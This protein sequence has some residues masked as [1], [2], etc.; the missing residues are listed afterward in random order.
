VAKAYYRRGSARLPLSFA[1]LE[2]GPLNL[3]LSDSYCY[4]IFSS[5]NIIYN[6]WILKRLYIRRIYGNN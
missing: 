5:Q 2:P 6:K 4:K 3:F 1:D